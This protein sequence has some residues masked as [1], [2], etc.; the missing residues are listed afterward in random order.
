MDPTKYTLRTFQYLWTVNLRNG[1]YV[2]LKSKLE[3]WAF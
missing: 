2:S 3:F 1:I